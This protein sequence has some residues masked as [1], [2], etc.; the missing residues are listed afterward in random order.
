MCGEYE[1]SHGEWYCEYCG[2]LRDT[3]AVDGCQGHLEERSCTSCGE[4]PKAP[5]RYCDTWIPA[6][7]YECPECG[8]DHRKKQKEFQNTSWL[9]GSSTVAVAFVSVGVLM[10]VGGYAL[11]PI[12]SL[13]TFVPFG[14]LVAVLGIV[15]GI[16]GFTLG[17]TAETVSKKRDAKPAG[18]ITRAEIRQESDEWKKKR[19]EELAN[20]AGSV[21]S[22]AENIAEIHSE[23]K[24]EKRKRK[25]EERKREEERRKEKEKQRLQ[26]MRE[27]INNR[28]QEAKNKNGTSVLWNMNC[29]KCGVSWA[30]I[31]KNKIVLSDDFDTIG[32][33]IINEE[34]YSLIQN[35]VRLQCDAPDCNHTDEFTKDS[36]WS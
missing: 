30:T 2:N 19:R 20:V 1:F 10:A 13:I 14:L 11:F 7:V 15:L 17:K 31:R 3:C 22:T 5:C 9:K 6:D 16:S 8:E 29:V 28:V 26:N 25:E 24:E 27:S 12:F 4:S 34:E 33:E 32:F 23:H 35:K 21:A 18:K 36:L